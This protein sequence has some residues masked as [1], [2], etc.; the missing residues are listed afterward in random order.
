MMMTTLKVSD[1]K[2]MKKLIALSVLSASLM[3]PLGAQAGFV[4]VDWKSVGD[5]SATLHEET[6]KEW[7]DLSLT[8]GMSMNAV[9][10]Q[11][12]EGGAF[13]GWRLPTFD[14]VM[15]LVETYSTYDF[16][17]T[18]WTV[19]STSATWVNRAT[20]WI[21]LFG[22]TVKPVDSSN[23]ITHSLGLF[24]D[25][26]GVVQRGG[27]SLRNSFGNRTGYFWGGQDMTALN[28]NSADPSYG[29]FLVS[30]G[31]VTLSSQQNP[32]LNINNPDAPINKQDP[33]VPPAFDVESPLT[34]GAFGLL[35]LGAFRRKKSS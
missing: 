23:G 16:T 33:V 20:G 19:S 4:A 6:G 28:V 30:D 15:E 34:A 35:L 2:M 21:N 26:A 8:D 9:V 1:N 10:S 14:E 5:G 25:S 17:D 32:E 7:L 27:A 29:I 22:I 12:G 18:T 31:G 11:L 24:L 3:L 13:A